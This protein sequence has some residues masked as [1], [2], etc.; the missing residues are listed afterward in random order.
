MNPW[1]AGGTETVPVLDWLTCDGH[2]S[3]GFAL[4]N[5][6]HDLLG[7]ANKALGT[8]L[9]TQGTK[10]PLWFTMVDKETIMM[11]NLDNI[12]I[13]VTDNQEVISVL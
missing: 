10:A 12:D 3:V 5:S 11:K 1:V 7:T 9:R 6:I 4:V 13:K 8:P 2:V